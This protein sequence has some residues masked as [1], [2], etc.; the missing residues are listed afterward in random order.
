MP[1][2]SAVT[3]VSTDSRQLIALVDGLEAQR[4]VLGDAIVEAALVPLRARLAAMGDT[5]V[6]QSLRQ[7]TVLFLD[8]VGSTALSQRIDPEDM[9]AVLDGLL[10][11]CTAIVESYDGKVLQYAGDS[12]L[13]A[14]G[15]ESTR[16]DDAE[17]AVRAGIALLAEGRHTS[18][19]VSRR[20]A[21]EAFDVR[22]GLHTGRV[23]LGG[24]VDAEAS[25]RGT[26]VHIAARMEQTAPAG[27][28]RISHETH[29]LVRGLFEAEEQPPLIVKG[30]DEPLRTFIVRRADPGV[31]HGALRGIEGVETRLVGRAAELSLLAT[32]FDT[33]VR[34]STLVW[35]TVVGDAGLGKSRL[36]NEFQHVCRV[37]N[38]NCRWLRG[39]AEPRGMTRGYGVLRDLLAQHCHILDSDTR[40]RAHGKL[41]TA[42]GPALGA[43]AEE[44]TAL[45]GQLIGLDYGASPHVAG[46]AHD[47]RQLRD[48]AF[49][50]LASL[51]ATMSADRP[52]VLMLDDLHWA[53][54]G[55]LAFVEFLANARANSPL[56]LLCAARPML[57]EREP[58][59]GGKAGRWSRIS[60]DPLDAQRSDELAASLLH[61][62][63]KAP[64]ALRQ[65]IVDGAEGNPYYME[66]LT[67]VLIDDGVIRT[68]GERWL[69]A[70][71][72]LTLTRVPT[73]LTGVLQARLDSLP[74]A[75]LTT[76]RLASVVGPVFWDEALERLQPGASK[77]LPTLLGKGLIRRQGV[78]GTFDRANEFTFKHHLLHQVTYDGALKRERLA[79]HRAIADWL[80]ECGGAHRTGDISARVAEHYARAEQ[81][82]L[83]AEHWSHAALDAL[84]RFAVDV[85]ASFAERVLALTDATDLA[86]RFAMQRVLEAIATRRAGRDAQAEALHELERLA[87]LLGDSIERAR[88]AIRR[89]GFEMRGGDFA[90]GLAHAARALAWAA[91]SSAEHSARAEELM[92]ASLS[93]LN[94]HAEAKQHAESA[95]AWARASGN[96][97]VQASVL[98]NKAL[99]LHENGDAADAAVLFAEALGLYREVGDRY[100]EAT[101]LSNLAEVVGTLGQHGRARALLIEAIQLARGIGHRQIEGYAQL[102]ASLIALNQGEPAAALGH[103]QAAMTI[104]CEVGDHWAESGA[105]TNAGHAELALGHCDTARAHYSAARQMCEQLGV[106]HLALVAIAGLAD[107]ALCSGDRGSALDHVNL[108]LERTAGGTTLEGVEEPL[109][110][111]LSCWRVLADALDPR[112]PAMLA[113][114]H[115]ELLALAA[116]IADGPGRQALL[117]DVPQHRDILAAWRSS[118]PSDD[119]NRRC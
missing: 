23:L 24:G 57:L 85:A 93:R 58:A 96:K 12:L 49:H 52:L 117:H 89:A 8:V 43:R 111:R 73:T 76:L 84:D 98:N 67:Q 86:R 3:H 50:A 90:S 105:L 116:R 114:A 88:V 87:E 30:S 110:L 33:A 47:G 36:L 53:D 115:A 51:L 39:Q 4:K 80:L 97:A 92:A 109:R 20:H 100:T 32:L 35:V 42:L 16:E 37:R 60:L 41:E 74:K 65:L 81:P 21:Y 82:G 40:E 44:G 9:H 59:W 15:A 26:A 119:A 18:E 69:V 63:D 104:L 94:R 45:I 28:L 14:F 68:D 31:A 78:G 107:A 54:P 95:L 55:S 99:V 77:A 6:A 64:A 56:L 91:P 17:R 71:D 27:A 11:R 66:E 106:D 34:D 112:A 61:R 48:R 75:E 25:I 5:A 29:R 7:V 62:I 70:D 38:L 113:A 1:A 46:I 118:G 10:T 72:R 83:A 2:K 13:A 22:I 79:W 103:A 19:L 101:V 108:I 102:N